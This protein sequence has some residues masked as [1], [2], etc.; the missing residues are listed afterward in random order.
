MWT[1]LGVMIAIWFVMR[2]VSDVYLN[3]VDAIAERAVK[4]MGDPAAIEKFRTE[5]QSRKEPAILGATSA[6]GGL[7]ILW[8]MMFKPF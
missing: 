4:N 5:L 1:A 2:R 7:I 3:A 8:L 6:I